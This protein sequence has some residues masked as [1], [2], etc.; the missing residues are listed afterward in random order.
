MPQL[1]RYLTELASKSQ[2]KD[3]GRIVYETVD[4]FTVICRSPDLLHDP[5]DDVTAILRN[6]NVLQGDGILTQLRLCSCSSLKAI[7][8][9]QEGKEIPVQKL[10]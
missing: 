4:S 10:Q 5:E 9:H 2:L 6:D 8:E 1:E 3:G 7:L